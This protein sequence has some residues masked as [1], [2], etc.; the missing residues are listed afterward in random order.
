M[1]TTTRRYH[2]ALA[3]TEARDSEILGLRAQ[4]AHKDAQ[5]AA[6]LEKLT[7]LELQL[8]RLPRL[9][10]GLAR[11]GDSL[12]TTGSSQ[13]RLANILTDERQ[14][15]QQLSTL[16]LD[17]RGHFLQMTQTLHEVSAKRA[18]TG[19]AIQRLNDHSDQI[20]QMV[21]LIGAIAKQTNLLALNAAIEAAR[22]GEAGRGFAV[23]ADE[24]RKLAERT[25]TATAQI[26][27][28]MAEVRKDTS[29]AW[30]N[31]STN[32]QLMDLMLE[33][34]AEATGGM[35]SVLASVQQ[36]NA[37]LIESAG[38]GRVEMANME[39]ITLKLE[40][41]KVLMGISKL[42]SAELPD[43]H[44][45]ALGQ[46][47]ATDEIRQRFARVPGYAEL[48]VPHSQVHQNAAQAVDLYH[49]GRLDEAFAAAARMEEANMQVMAGLQRLLA[50]ASA[51]AIDE[52]AH[53]AHSGNTSRPSDSAFGKAGTPDL[54][55]ISAGQ[56]A[57]IV[58]GIFKTTGGIAS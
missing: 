29:D 56:P 40:V 22:A 44:A 58:G 46:W 7:G 16:S 55:L 54:P 41:Y 12:T 30:Q 33:Q 9:F 28:V 18:E 11:F 3:Q 38:L 51:V 19:A 10:S 6:Q 27:E 48:D 20:G 2:E 49:Q 26:N 23:V 21:E 42:T 50:S 15:A 47:Y 32:A 24:V 1:L 35:D 39:E 8:A 4:L 25:S 52:H 31:V 45:C 37:G 14:A 13:R 34:S 57:R 36:M 17:Y 43:H 5:F 53:P